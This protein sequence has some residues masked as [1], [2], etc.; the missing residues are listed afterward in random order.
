MSKNETGGGEGVE[1]LKNEPFGPERNVPVPTRALLDGRPEFNCGQYTLKW[2]HMQRYV[3]AFTWLFN[4][5]SDC[6]I[7]IK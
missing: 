6:L 1:V 7:A 2:Y 4:Y 5:N 3:A